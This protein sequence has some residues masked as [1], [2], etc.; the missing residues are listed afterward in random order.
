MVGPWFTTPWRLVSQ[1]HGAV[2]WR[3]WSPFQSHVLFPYA[4][5]RHRPVRSVPWTP[6]PVGLLCGPGHTLF[7]VPS[8]FPIIPCSYPTGPP[9]TLW[10]GPT[11]TS[12]IRGPFRAPSTVRAL[13]APAPSPCAASH[14]VLVPWGR[15]LALATRPVPSRLFFPASR[16]FFGRLQPS[17]A[18]PLG[19]LPSRVLFLCLALFAPFPLLSTCVACSP[20]DLWWVPLPGPRAP[21]SL[22][23]PP[24]SHPSLLVLFF[25][26]MILFLFFFHPRSL[27]FPFCSVLFPVARSL[28]AARPPLV[29]WG[30]VC[31]FS[32]RRA[33]FRV[34]PSSLHAPPTTLHRHL[35]RFRSM[36]TSSLI[37]ILWRGPWRSPA[38]P[39]GRS[40]LASQSFKPTMKLIFFLPSPLSPPLCL[41]PALLVLFSCSVWSP[42]V[43]PAPWLYLARFHAPQ[44]LRPV[45]RPVGGSWRPPQTTLRGDSPI[46]LPRRAPLDQFPHGRAG[47]PVRLNAGHRHGVSQRETLSSFAPLLAPCSP[48]LPRPAS[49]S[50]PSWVSACSAVV[51]FFLLVSPYSRSLLLPRA[52]R[53]PPALPRATPVSQPCAPSFPLLPSHSPSRCRPCLY[54]C[55]LCLSRAVTRVCHPRALPLPLSVAPTLFPGVS[56][57]LVFSRSPSLTS[58]WLP[59]ALCGGGGCLRTGLWPC[60]RRGMDVGFLSTMSHSIFQRNTE[61]TTVRRL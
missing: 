42:L 11:G 31:G 19:P 53:V 30:V 57:T 10:R 43:V 61:R 48:H 41:P 16:F 22:A 55:P 23:F 18:G 21:L 40:S 60:P 15:L 8:P 28:C 51:V 4:T 50:C 37:A 44:G 9:A 38:L 49:S 25:A 36:L 59:Y 35:S 20:Q 47:R 13:P 54:V 33:L 32:F 29:L 26:A 2:A 52:L 7:S 45:F 39:G 56:P 27:V 12:S 24:R 46:V 34:V 1:S 6:Y 5:S 3:F 17:G 14:A 58:S